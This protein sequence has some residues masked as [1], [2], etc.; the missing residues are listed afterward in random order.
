MLWPAVSAAGFLVATVLVVALAR[1]Q[2]A[3]WERARR[4]ER[5]ARR[6]RP[7]RGRAVPA[8]AQPSPGAGV[9]DA[10]RR[11]ERPRRGGPPRRRWRLP[12]S[13]VHP[14]VRTLHLPGRRRRARTPS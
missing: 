5:K 10:V 7:R 1:S 6:R 11:P 14:T 2:T 13:A 9:E 4:E 8:G 12:P 3:R